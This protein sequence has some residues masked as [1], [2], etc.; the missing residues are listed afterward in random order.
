M[1][2]LMIGKSFLFL[3]VRVVPEIM[4]SKRSGEGGEKEEQR[5]RGRREGGSEEER[6]E[7]S[8]PTEDTE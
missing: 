6:E 8:Q 1:N 4:L 3:R 2:M 5:W 7:R